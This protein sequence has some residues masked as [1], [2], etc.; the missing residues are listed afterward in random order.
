MVARTTQKANTTAATRQKSE[1]L[2]II[3]VTRFAAYVE[4]DTDTYAVDLETLTCTC[5]A[6]HHGLRCSHAMAT[7]REVARRS[8]QTFVMFG[9]SRKHAESFAA[10]QV[11][12][13]K[14]AEVKEI[15]GF[16]LVMYGTPAPSVVRPVRSAAEID[17]RADA[18]FA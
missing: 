15:A 3:S 16:M 14:V 5:E 12:R 18:L 1:R 8:G 7:L 13:G 2:E 10:M 4:G 17:A 11:A 6:G 9:H